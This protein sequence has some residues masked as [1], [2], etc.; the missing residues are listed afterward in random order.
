MKPVK[1]LIMALAIMFAANTYAQTLPKAEM[2]DMSGKTLR[3]ESWIDGKTPFVISFWGS[4]CKPCMQEL[5]AMS[6][7]YEEWNEKT[8]FRM[9]AIATDDSRSVARA[10]SLAKGRGWDDFILA[11]D[12]NGDMRRAMSVTTTPRVFLF[13][14][15]GKQVYMHIGYKP[16]DEYEL[17]RKIKELYK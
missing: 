14:K 16:G 17:Q 8:P 2:Q 7:N 5:D 11:F 6:E 12:V 1:M 9:I 15:N 13:D 4:T 10:R 3:S